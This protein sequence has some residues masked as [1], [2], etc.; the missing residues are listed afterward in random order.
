MSTLW[1]SLSLFPSTLPLP[2][3]HQKV[4]GSRIVWLM[5]YLKGAVTSLLITYSALPDDKV[6][7]FTIHI[8][9]SMTGFCMDAV[10][11]C[12]CCA[13]F[14]AWICCMICCSS[15]WSAAVSGIICR[16]IWSKTCHIAAATAKATCTRI[17]LSGDNPFRRRTNWKTCL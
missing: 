3:A 15:L 6:G 10:G 8:N 1:F 13:C 7:G 4:H 9:H 5:A 12:S 16:V 14:S 17:T 11:C 2:K